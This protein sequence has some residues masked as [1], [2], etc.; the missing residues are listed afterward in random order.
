MTHKY[1]PR[2]V[3]ARRSYTPE[4]VARLFGINKHTVFRWFKIKNG[5]RPLEAHK[6]PL[7]VMGE[8]IRRFLTVKRKERKF[9]LK[10]NECFCLKCKRPSRAKAGTEKTVPT[11]KTIGK[12]PRKQFFR[13]AKCERCGTEM[14]RLV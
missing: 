11:G 2:L 13:I 8:E 12:E 7:I 1:N 5:L 3:T 4:E 6:K 14:R 10:E 9:P